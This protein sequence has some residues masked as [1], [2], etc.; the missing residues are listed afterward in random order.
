MIRLYH[1]EREVTE[2]EGGIPVS[3]LPVSTPSFQ[4]EMGTEKRKR[5][6]F[7]I[8]LEHLY[9]RNHG[10][11]HVVTQTCPAPESDARSSL[12]HTTIDSPIFIMEKAHPWG[13]SAR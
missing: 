12:G 11:H 13:S 8:Q 2:Q 10:N 3:L 6:R 4:K 5:G 1:S 7:P 9:M